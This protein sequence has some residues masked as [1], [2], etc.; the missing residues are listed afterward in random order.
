MFFEFFV[1]FQAS[2]GA[3]CEETVLQARDKPFFTAFTALLKDNG[4]HPMSRFHYGGNAI[5]PELG[6]IV[7]WD[8]TPEKLMLTSGETIYISTYKMKVKPVPHHGMEASASSGSAA[9]AV[10]R[11]TRMRTP[12]RSPRRAAV[13]E[14]WQGP[15]EHCH[16]GHGLTKDIASASKD[17]IND[18]STPK[19]STASDQD[20]QQ[21]DRDQY[22]HDR[23]DQKCDESH[24]WQISDWASSW[25]I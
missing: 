1:R 9:S 14:E 10:R 12:S 18:P 17:K 13:V 19:E 15:Q 22:D 16:E 7:D 6:S 4:L 2:T 21:H 25:R 3:W 8:T 23:R 24:E 20:D 11:H 5:D